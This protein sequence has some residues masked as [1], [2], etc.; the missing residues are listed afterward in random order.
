[1]DPDDYAGLPEEVFEALFPPP[2]EEC[3]E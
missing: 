1:V 3:D 2:D